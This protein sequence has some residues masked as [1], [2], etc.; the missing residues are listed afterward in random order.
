VYRVTAAG[1][2][3]YYDRAALRT[4]LAAAAE[5]E[6]LHAMMFGTAPEW[7]SEADVAAGLRKLMACCNVGSAYADRVGVLAAL[8]FA[9]IDG[10]MTTMAAQ[11]LVE[12]SPA[13]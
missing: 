1:R 3:A 7:C 12:R 4:P 11:G 6:V 9:D 2:R 8:V 13:P 5:R 10:F